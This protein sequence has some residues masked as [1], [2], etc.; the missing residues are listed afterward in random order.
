[1]GKPKIWNISKTAVRRAE[2][3]FGIRGTAVHIGRLLL[4]TDSFSLVGVIRCTLHNLQF[5]D[6]QNTT[7]PIYIQFHPNFIQ[8]ILIMG[9]YRLVLFC[10][11]AENYKIKAR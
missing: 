11:T 8:G 7:P 4:K 5:W 3:N 1:M 2:Q 10:R 6:L 9:Q